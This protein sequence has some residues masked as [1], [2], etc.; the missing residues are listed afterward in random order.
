MITKFS[1]RRNN[2]LRKSGVPAMLTDAA[3]M[4]KVEE[5]M[6]LSKKSLV[7]LRPVCLNRYMSLGQKDS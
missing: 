6:L 2:K 7:F 5:E 4:E 1:I 3:T